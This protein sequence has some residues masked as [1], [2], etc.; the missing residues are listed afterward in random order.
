M[1]DNKQNNKENN[2]LIDEKKV[3]LKADEVKPEVSS[4]LDNADIESQILDSKNEAS[5]K[6]H[7]RAFYDLKSRAENNYAV[8]KNKIGKF[9]KKKKSERRNKNKRVVGESGLLAGEYQSVVNPHKMNED[10]KSISEAVRELEKQHK[11]RLMDEK[12]RLQEEKKK[13]GLRVNPSLKNLSRDRRISR[14]NTINKQMRKFSKSVKRNEGQ[15]VFSKLNE[16]SSH[17]TEPMRRTRKITLLIVLLLVSFLICLS[18]LMPQFYLSEIQINGCNYLAEDD[19]R[20]VVNLKPGEHFVQMINGGLEEVLKLRNKQ[21]EDRLKERFPY[22]K[23]VEAMVVFP[24][25]FQVNI[26]ESKELAY[27]SIPGGYALLDSDARVIKINTGYKPSG[28][29]LIEGM[30]FNSLSIGQKVEVDNKHGLY[31]ALIA[32]D[33]LLRADQDKNDGNSIL[34]M[35]DSVTLMD[36]QNIY[37]NFISIQ[38]NKY[39]RVLLSPKSDYVGEIYWLRNAI[40]IGAFAGLN[41]GYLDLTGKNR[42]YVRL[43]NN[44]SGLMKASDE[45]FSNGRIGPANLSSEKEQEDNKATLTADSKSEEDIAEAIPELS[46]EKVASSTID[47]FGNL[48]ESTEVDQEVPRSTFELPNIDSVKIPSERTEDDL[49]KNLN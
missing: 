43:D 38:K 19:I 21:V 28:I 16:A 34:T 44:Y 39:F 24:S 13:S 1:S 4:D 41:D 17:M 15:N 45:I 30:D 49:F 2:N 47:P 35:L 33:A 42:V 8:V 22:I 6:K 12:K 31:N 10:S 37:L 36:N 46:D 27:L 48:I 25:V 18:A 23:E 20:R 11:K 29:P 40:R 7:S 26:K 3:D 9:S 5:S 32:I 14:E